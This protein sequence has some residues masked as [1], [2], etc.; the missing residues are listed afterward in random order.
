MQIRPLT[1]VDETLIASVAQLLVEEFAEHWPGAWSTLQ[2]AMEE[3]RAT[4]DDE[5]VNFVALDS[6]D[7]VLG[8][9]AGEHSYAMVWELHPLVVRG[10][11]QKQGVGRALVNAF[12]QAVRERGAMTV[13][14]GSDDEDNMTTLAGKELYHDLWRHVREIQNIKGHPYEF[15][16]KLGYQIVGVIPDA[17]GWGKPDIVMAKRVGS[18]GANA[19]S[20]E[21]G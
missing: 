16:E 18:V 11:R 14:L 1:V 2:D 17:N 8:W 5:H 10:A 7:T 6:D 13:M 4:L 21:G 20:A 19:S 15:Y 9:I 12:E 3:V